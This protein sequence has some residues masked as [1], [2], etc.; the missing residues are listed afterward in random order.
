MSWRLVATHGWVAT[1]QWA[2]AAASAAASAACAAAPA[3]ASAAPAIAPAASAAAPA[4]LEAA[5]AAPAIAPAAEAV[6]SPIASMPAAASGAAS[7]AASAAGS[8]GASAGLLQPT[9]LRV[10]TAKRTANLFIKCS[11]CIWTQPLAG[12]RNVRYRN[13]TRQATNAAKHLSYQCFQRASCKLLSPIGDKRLRARQVP[14]MSL[15]GDTASVVVSAVPSKRSTH[16]NVDTGLRFR[17]RS[18][19]TG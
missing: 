16:A 17:R 5:S 9:R 6:A 8:A 13:A 14:E 19:R 3:A 4:A 11:C 15:F 7:I 12:S 2:G 18:C 10:A 1:P